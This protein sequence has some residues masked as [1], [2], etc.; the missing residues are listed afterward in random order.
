RRHTGWPR[1]WS[2]DVCSSDLGGT[3]TDDQDPLESSP[4]VVVPGY[5]LEDD[6]GRLLMEAPPDSVGNRSR[7]LVDLLEHEVLIAALRR[8]HQIGRAPCRE[9]VDVGVEV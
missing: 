6:A 3:A 9:R 7:L 1:D 2:S 5:I 4:R 8:R